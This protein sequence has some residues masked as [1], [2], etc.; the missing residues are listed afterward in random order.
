M[1]IRHDSLEEEK[2]FVNMTLYLPT[3]SIACQVLAHSITHLLIAK[4]KDHPAYLAYLKKG[5]IAL[6]PL[7]VVRICLFPQNFP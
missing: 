1:M 7:S 5:E 3:K 6:P 2:Y 4:L